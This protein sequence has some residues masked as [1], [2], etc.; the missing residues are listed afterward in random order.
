LQDEVCNAHAIWL[1]HTYTLQQSESK[2]QQTHSPTHLGQ[3]ATTLHFCL[4]QAKGFKG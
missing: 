4:V 2:E 3:A 1:C